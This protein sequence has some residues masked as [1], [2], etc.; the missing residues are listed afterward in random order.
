VHDAVGTEQ[1]KA[2]QQRQGQGRQFHV[3]TYRRGPS[4]RGPV[5]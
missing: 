5:E 4:T 2:E 3:T 1:A